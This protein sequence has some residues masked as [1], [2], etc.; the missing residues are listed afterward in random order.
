MGAFFHRVVSFLLRF[1][2]LPIATIYMHARLLVTRYRLP[3]DQICSAGWASRPSLAAKLKIAD[4]LFDAGQH[5]PAVQLTFL[6][7]FSSLDSHPY[8][9]LF[10]GTIYIYIYIDILL[11]DCYCRSSQ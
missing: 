5:R 8:S 10:F 4:L 9:K 3:R 11:F 6:L 1:I 2:L 7:V